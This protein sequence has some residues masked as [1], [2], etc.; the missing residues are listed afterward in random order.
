MKE[1]EVEQFFK[2]MALLPSKRRLVN[3]NIRGSLW[4]IY[5]PQYSISGWKSS[6]NNLNKREY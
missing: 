5:L 2:T 6:K 1:G 3:P 4:P